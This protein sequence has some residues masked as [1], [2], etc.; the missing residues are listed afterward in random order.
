M[1]SG[2]AMVTSALTTLEPKVFLDTVRE[3][4]RKA[5]AGKLP[6]E[7]VKTMGCA[8]GV[9]PIRAVEDAKQK[10]PQ[11][12]LN[13]AVKTNHRPRRAAGARHHRLRWRKRGSL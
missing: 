7:M 5:G 10:R 12:G 3:R 2:E 11:K 4:V 8:G 1:G 6:D 13:V 9:C